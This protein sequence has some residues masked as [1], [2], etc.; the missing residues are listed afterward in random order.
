MSRLVGDLILLAKSRRPDFLQVRPTDL[1]ELT[2]ALA[3]KVR[4]LGDRDWVLAEEGSGTVHLDEQRVTQAV[5]ALADNAVKH[6]R[7]R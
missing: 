5:L 3:A 4:A 6:T 1:A 2:S 7:S